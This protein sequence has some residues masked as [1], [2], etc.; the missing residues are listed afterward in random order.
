MTDKENK[1]ALDE[2]RTIIN[3]C[4]KEMAALFEKRMK[5]AA[6]V[7]NYKKAH[8]L[9]VYDAKREAEVISRNS[10]RIEDPGVRSYYV[11]FLQETMDLSKSYQ[12][13]ILEGMR[14]A[15]S[16]VEGAFAN[17]IAR[18]IFP[19]TVLVSCPDFASAYKSVE[20]G[21]CDAAV[22]PVENSFAGEV[23]QV[24]DLMF[25]GSLF[26]NGMYELRVTQNLL[27]VK[28]TSIDNIKTVVSHPQALMQ[29]ASYIKEHG[30]APEEAQNT[31][32]AAKYVAEKND[33]SVAA[34]ASKETAE[35]YGLKLLDH[36][37]NENA[38]NTTRFAVLSRVQNSD[39][40][41][42]N[43]FL[44]FFTVNHTAGALAEA[45]GVI[46]KYG[47]NMKVL[48][49]RPMREL[50]WQYY[51]YVEAEGDKDSDKAKEMLEELGRHCDMLKILGQYSAK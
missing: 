24:S 21:D 33:P 32:L 37:I 38:T 4:D 43:V 8:G 40:A 27:G 29:C 9:P 22:L 23:G 31:A 51:F 1:N 44:L 39:R 45:I 47:F 18:K 5:A 6:M 41:E 50:A 49:S 13:R 3:S 11:K 20:N 30:F 10:L 7:A 26:V 25:K 34:I 42:N 19:E 12:H 28:G 46:G 16:G 48:R 14:V 17:I 36:D 15:Y 35:L 2:A